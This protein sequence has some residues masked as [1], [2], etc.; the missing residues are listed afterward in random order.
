M[1]G[2]RLFHSHLGGEDGDGGVLVGADAAAVGLDLHLSLGLLRRLLS[3]R[4]GHRQVARRL[5]RC[6]GHRRVRAACT[7]WLS[8]YVSGGVVACTMRTSILLLASISATRVA[9]TDSSMISLCSI[10]YLC[11][12][13]GTPNEG[14]GLPWAWV[15]ARVWVWVGARE[16][17]APLALR[18]QVL[19]PPCHNR[20]RA[21][22]MR[23]RS[24][25]AGTAENTL[26]PQHR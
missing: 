9:P 19:L 2:G 24:R 14:E 12:G 10:S 13:E 3:L 11:E 15:R 21:C 25:T 7:T 1:A 18:E 8:I 16:R 4:L 26:V 6:M 20:E 17:A 22:H 5:P 23:A